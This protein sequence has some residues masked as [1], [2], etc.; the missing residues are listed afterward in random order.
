M[1]TAGREKRPEKVERGK[2]SA[3]VWK[4][5]QRRKG[6]EGAQW[7]RKAKNRDVSTGPLACPFARLLAR[8]LIHS[9]ARGKA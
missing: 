7:A 3:W 6:G 4:G 5:G 9:Q 2:K 8:S 1:K